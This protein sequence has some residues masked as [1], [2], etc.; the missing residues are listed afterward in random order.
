MRIGKRVREALGLAT[1]IDMQYTAFKDSAGG[2]K[3]ERYAFLDFLIDIGLSN[4]I[5]LWRK[6]SGQ[7]LIRGENR[8]LPQSTLLPY[9]LGVMVSDSGLVRVLLSAAYLQCDLSGVRRRREGGVEWSTAGPS[10]IE[11]IQRVTYMARQ[12]HAS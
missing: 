1:E 11:C 8:C 4:V 6:G 12:S 9:P 10:P 7:R 5:L 2:R 3:A